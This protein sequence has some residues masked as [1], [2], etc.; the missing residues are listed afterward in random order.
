LIDA[1]VIKSLIDKL[2]NT[3]NMT[4]Q[5]ILLHLFI[6]C[7]AGSGL[8][9]LTIFLAFSFGVYTSFPALQIFCVYTGEIYDYILIIL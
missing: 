7:D 1:F 2:L 4:N 9:M 3:P 5:E 6:K 8:N